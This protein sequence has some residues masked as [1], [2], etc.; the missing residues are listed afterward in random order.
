MQCRQ[1]LLDESIPAEEQERWERH[2]ESCPACQEY[3][4]QTDRCD[5]EMLSLARRVGDPTVTPADPRLMG[6]LEQLLHSE[7]APER[8][9]QP[10]PADLYFLRPSSQP[11][12]LGTLGDYEVAEVIGQGGMGVV[13][14]AFDPE[15]NRFV[16][17]KVLAAAVAGSAVARRRFKREAQAAA[18][19]CHD[20]VVAVHGVGEADG[21][22][23][24]VMQYIE[25]ESLQHRLDRCGPL[26]A[27][28]VARVGMQAAL[29]LAAAHAQGLVHR[30]IKPANLL[31]EGEPGA[32]ATGVEVSATGVGVSA[33]GGK[34]KITDF[35][36]ARTADDVG[37]T[38]AG[39]VAGTPEYMAPEQA[40]GETIDHRA[41]LFSLGS[42]L[43]ACCTG[44]PPFRGA[45][46]VA[47][48]RQVSDEVPVP[49]RSCN[50]A[51]PV[52]LE[53]LIARLTA[54]AP[55]ERIRSAAELAALLDGFLAHLRQPAAVPAPALPPA[56]QEAPPGGAGTRGRLFPGSRM[57]ALVLVAAVLFGVQALLF[58]AAPAHDP[59]PAAKKTF[60][61]DFRTADFDPQVLV[62]FG[63][64]VEWD[65]KGLRIALE[66]GRD[67][68]HNTGIDTAFTVR[69][70]F[71]ITTGYEILR[72]ERPTMGYGVGVGLYAPID[73][74][75]QNAV[76]LSRRLMP[77][78]TARFISNRMTPDNGKINFRVKTMP[79]GSTVGKLRLER[80]GPV[81]RTFV[82]DGAD[83]PFV[84]IDELEFDTADLRFV[85]VEG[86]NGASQAGFDIR[87]SDLDI[88]STDL[89]TQ[90]GAE[91][92]AEASSGGRRWS[93]AAGL[94]VLLIALTALGVR[95][96][97][98]RRSRAAGRT[99]VPSTEEKPPTAAPIVA[100]G[101][102]ACGHN[103]KARVEL[104]GKKGRC[105]RCGG[106]VLVPGSSEAIQPGKPSL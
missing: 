16:A 99:P 101:C 55:A 11:G 20:H 35:G 48:L 7:P 5:A 30:D 6:I 18:A 13:L 95:L 32:S 102:P 71:E 93:A 82:A 84:Q 75:T 31:L 87:L 53:G 92:G 89:P 4:D 34:V 100:F 43:Y 70:D 57:L 9:P 17:I 69:G 63:P 28:E 1:A 49:V 68:R 72:A 61:H 47:V 76:S 90:S 88:R 83:A 39:V 106:M 21:L 77:D 15:L 91:P 54:K 73:P 38:Q 8:P 67:G 59:P 85:R 3:F 25:G 58:Q 44:Q 78:G 64:G 12:V 26:E 60:H 27:E 19:V 51:I 33:T 42:V 74:D 52:W 96:V 37:L 23:Y 103:L 41:D 86:D 22:P 46:A 56:P 14:K 24:L 80:V 10:E 81:L 98:R 79:S 2:V 29:G 40:R 45:S 50:P 66:P 105:P 65:G 62:P 36:L 97:V 94:I 104:A